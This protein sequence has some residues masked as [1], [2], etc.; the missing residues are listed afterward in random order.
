MLWQFWVMERN[1][2]RWVVSPPLFGYIHADHDPS[3]PLVL[4]VPE[5]V[6]IDNCT[7]SVDLVDLIVRIKQ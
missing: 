3:K 1:I 5:D 2:R 4:N 6:C 7:L